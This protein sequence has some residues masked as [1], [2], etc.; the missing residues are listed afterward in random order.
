MYRFVLLIEDE[1]G[2]RNF[3]PYDATS[4]DDAEDQALAEHNQACNIITVYQEI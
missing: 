2:D 3:Y 4:A 1:N